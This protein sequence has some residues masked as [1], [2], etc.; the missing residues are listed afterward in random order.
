MTH[1]HNH[2]V[3]TDIITINGREYHQD[4][5]S[6][7]L[8]SFCQIYGA[9]T[10]ELKQQNAEADRLKINIFKT[11][12]AMKALSE[13]IESELAELD[14]GSAKIR[15]INRQDVELP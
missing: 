14:K 5:L 8:L 7:E 12:A 2:E 11:E 15:P 13:R 3:D 10:E 6:Q 1:E 4:E 9:W